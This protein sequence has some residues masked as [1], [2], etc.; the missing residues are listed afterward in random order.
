[1]TDIRQSNRS[2]IH[3]RRIGHNLCGTTVEDMASMKR[4]VREFAVQVPEVLEKTS[5]GSANIN[6]VDNALS[7]SGSCRQYSN[8]GREQTKGIK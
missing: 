6:I 1:M 3:S 4:S 7:P 8:N 2:I 5:G